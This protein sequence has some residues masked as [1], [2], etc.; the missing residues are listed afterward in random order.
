MPSAL[1]VARW[2]QVSGRTLE[3]DLRWAYEAG[4]ETLQAYLR[5]RERVR[6]GIYTLSRAYEAGPETLQAYLRVR[7]RVSNGIYT[8]SRAYEAGLETLQAYLRVP[9][10]PRRLHLV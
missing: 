7:E 6:N 5:V 8:L 4:L 1:R 10:L 2:G 3:A 9:P